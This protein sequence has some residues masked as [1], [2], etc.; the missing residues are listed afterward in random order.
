MHTP[1]RLARRRAQT[2]MILVNSLAFELVMLCLTYQAS[3]GALVINIVG[4]VISGT[5]CA[6]I[7]VPTMVT[8]DSTWE[9]ACPRPGLNT[10]HVP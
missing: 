8:L 6:L 3:N 7:V 1:I 2:T 10:G 9:G 5:V 4:V